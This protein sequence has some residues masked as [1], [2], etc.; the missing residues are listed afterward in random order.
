MVIKSYVSRRRGMYKHIS[1]G[2]RRVARAHNNYASQAKAVRNPR[3]GGFLGIE[4]KFLDSGQK[5]SA[6]TTSTSQA[7]GEHDP[8]LGDCLNSIL[9]GT[10]EQNRDGRKV[11]LKSV[12]VHGTVDSL[13]NAD[14]G[15]MPSQAYF[16]VAIVLDTQTNGTQMSSE[17]AFKNLASDASS[18]ANPFLNLEYQTRFRVIKYVKLRAPTP[19]AFA[20]GTNTGTISGY[21]VPFSM[22]ASLNIPVNFVSAAGGI[23]DIVDNS[24]HVI[25]W[26]S[27]TTLLPRLNYGARVRFMG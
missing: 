18:S 5:D 27:S 22:Y 17:L 1:K 21:Q 15:D 6:L 12:L 2:N 19:N 11:I 25:A 24:L 7:G 9:Q 10:N 3:T 14:A 23:G 13:G 4:R 8:T 26:T 16:Y 20:D